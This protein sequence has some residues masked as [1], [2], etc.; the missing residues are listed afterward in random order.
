MRKSFYIGKHHVGV[1]SC[2]IIAEIGSNHDQK[3]SRAFEMIRRAAKAG[4]NA[5]KFQLFKAD[6]IAANID[7]PETRLKDKFAKFGKNVYALYKD[8]ELPVSWLKELKNC[9]KENKIDFLATPFDEESADQLAHIGVPAM[10]VASFEI[11]HIPLLKHL[12]KLKLPILLSTGMANLKEI[13]QAVSA[14]EGVGEQRIALFHCGIQYPAPF[15]SVHL[16]CLDTLRN[17]FRCPVGYSDHTSGI[18]VSVAATALGA[19]LYE[20]HVTIPGGKSPDHDFA[21]NMD[22]FESMVRAMRECEQA[23]GNHVKQVQAVEKV[24]LRRGRR[25][26][27][28][29]RNMK[30]GD[31]F[32]SENL[33]VLR[34]GTGLAPSL[35]EKILGKKATRDLEAPALVQKGDWR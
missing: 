25:S 24:H 22:E 26:C 14:I 32:T 17:A 31:I 9:C 5:V 3:K 30:K 29:V 10:K 19:N 21:L 20:K 33:S 27:F 23:L 34:P 8:M 11:T 18:S 13:R 4:A 6:K 12:G 1:D 2:Y 28:I 35:L 7:I 16:R 15:D